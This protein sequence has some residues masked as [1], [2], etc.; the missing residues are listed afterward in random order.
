M[1]FLKIELILLVR[2]G[3]GGGWGVYLKMFRG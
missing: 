3:G 2:G 1:K